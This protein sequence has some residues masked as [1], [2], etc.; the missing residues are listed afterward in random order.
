VEL[1]VN[2]HIVVGDSARLPDSSRELEFCQNLSRM[3]SRRDIL[4]FCFG[5]VLVVSLGILAR[6]YHTIVLISIDNSG[7]GRL[8]SEPE[9]ARPL[10]KRGDW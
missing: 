3:Y 8:T 7:S 9:P 5:E 1:P 2:R 6:E 10:A 4:I